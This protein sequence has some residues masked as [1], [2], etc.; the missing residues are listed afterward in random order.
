[1]VPVTVYGN[2]PGIENDA[3]RSIEVIKYLY[4]RTGDLVQTSISDIISFYSN[5]D[6]ASR[7]IFQNHLRIFNKKSQ[8]A[9]DWV[10]SVY[11]KPIINSVVKQ[12]AKFSLYLFLFHLLHPYS[13]GNVSL[14]TT[15]PKDKPLIYINYFDDPR[16]LEVSVVGIKM[17]TRIV[18]TTYFKAIG[19]FLGRMNWPECDNFK[20]DSKDYWTCICINLVTNVYHPVGTAKVGSDTNYSV[21]NS[22]LKVHKMYGLRVIDASIMPSIT[23]GNTNAPTIMIGERGSDLIKKDYNK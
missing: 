12:N 8:K 10:K 16:D 7:P 11:K 18:N 5:E 14:N 6:N 2:D 3:D 22:T 21:V 20:L 9:R 19:G 1:M 13:K 15:N 23:S 17:L 4:N